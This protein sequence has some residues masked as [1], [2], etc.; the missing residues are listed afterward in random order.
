MVDAV[1]VQK[2]PDGEV[3][4]LEMSDVSEQEREQ[5]GAIAGALIGFGMEGEEGMEAGAA[6]GAEAVSEEGGFLGD[7]TAW[8]IA[9][10]IPLGTAAAVA[11]LEHRWA[12]PLRDAILRA[13]GVPL[14]DTWIHPQDLVEYG[15]VAAESSK[16][17]TADE[18]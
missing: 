4:A 15:I 6:A 2:E 10:T 12:I 18:G 14:A 9:D 7:E 13:G 11:L 8:S 5:Y 1:V 3:H 16:R 17:E